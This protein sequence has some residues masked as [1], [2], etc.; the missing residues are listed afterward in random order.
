M[1]WN[2]QFIYPKTVRSSIDGVRKYSIGQEK[3]PSVTT[4]ISSTQDASKT[5]SLNKWKARVGEVEAERIKNTAATRGTA[6]HTYLEHHVKGGNVLDL[7][8]VG[9]EARSM[10]QTI[11]EKGFPDLEEVWG[12]ECTLF[13][14]GLYAGQTDLCGIYQGRESI[15]DF[16]QSNKPKRAEWIGDYKLQ[17][18]AY[19]TAHD[20]IFGTNIEQGVILMCTPD[21]F[22]QRFIVNGPEFREWK[23]KWLQK[24][25][26]YYKSIG[27]A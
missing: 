4:I 14:P 23:W 6:M 22:F 12:V 5:D 2:K 1:K 17:L 16:K 8:D 26:D 27:V 18:A 21:N 15:V 10:G 20:C 7:T 24:I 13:Y 19:A 3:L 11:I 9:R 25:S